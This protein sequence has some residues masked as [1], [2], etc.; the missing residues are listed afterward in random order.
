MVTVPDDAMPADHAA[1]LT[2]AGWSPAGRL[3][4]GAHGTTWAV[5]RTDETGGRAAVRHLEAGV[6][7]AGTCTERLAV[8]RG[9]A[10]P[11][12]ARVLDVV[13][14]GADGLLVLVEEVTG[15]TL[16]ALVGARG[17]LTPGE[18]VTVVTG[19]ARALATLHGAGL[20]HGDVAPSNVVIDTSGAPVLIDLWSAV[21]ADRDL[22]TPGFASAAVLGGSV[23]VP[24]DDVHALGRLGRWALGERMCTE[25][26]PVAE[27]LLAACGTAPTGRLTS[28]ELEA[29]C[30]AAARPEPV[31][32]PDPAALAR[33]ELLGGARTCRA[34]LPTRRRPAPPRGATRALR[35]AGGAAR[36]AGAAPRRAVPR[37]SSPI[38]RPSRGVHRAR[39][40]RTATPFARVAP[41]IVLGVGV[42]VLGG[43]GIFLH[44]TGVP[45]RPAPTAAVASPH[46]TTPTS[47]DGQALLR[48][49]EVS[50]A[51][52]PPEAQS[53]LGSGQVPTD[54]AEAA[55]YLTTVRAQVLISGDPGRL[56][57]IDVPG[58]AAYEADRAI[59]TG[60]GG[61]VGSVDGLTCTV[62]STLV[63]DDA[64]VALVDVTYALSAHT[65]RD[66][67]GA[68]IAV[69][70]A[71]EP[72][73]VRL[74]LHR[75]DGEWRVSDVAATT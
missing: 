40:P 18:V 22:G 50:T 48:D 2:A 33:A 73:T 43:G 72:Q 63:D 58:S 44:S 20:V 53:G 21:G 42:L 65:R 38:E 31:L 39:G 64:A 57:E 66:P 51:T 34:V 32:V 1:R 62:E 7:L 52:A 30:C 46:P 8:L 10:D 26:D 29:R 23:P 36:A 9:L 16:A 27:A 70:P 41:A 6:V 19:I 45:D 11:H 75:T 55:R 61:S 37:R 14:D 24:A 68:V 49:Q 69:V 60:L 12:V 4:T 47:G 56:A 28:V 15:P 3:G 67:D 35:R 74:T 59:V 17:M 71:T 25:G 13:D 54:P 5:R